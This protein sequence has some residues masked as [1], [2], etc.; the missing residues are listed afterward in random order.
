MNS[1]NSLFSEKFQGNLEQSRRVKLLEY[2]KEMYE[3]VPKLGRNLYEFEKKKGNLKGHLGKEK[4]QF[5]NERMPTLNENS[6]EAQLDHMID[7]CERLMSEKKLRESDE[8]L[9]NE[10]RASEYFDDSREMR[11]NDGVTEKDEERRMYTFGKEGSSSVSRDDVVMRRQDYF[12]NDPNVRRNENIYY[13]QSR[14]PRESYMGNQLNE[15]VPLSFRNQRPQDFDL[16]RSQSREWE[17]PQRLPQFEAS[18]RL[19]LPIAKWQDVKFD[20][21]EEGL[22]R[23]LNRVTQM[24]IAE[25]ASKEDLFRNKI[26]LFKGNAADWLSTQT[27]FRD[28][29]DLVR[30]LT[31]YVRGSTSD[32]DRLRSIERMRQTPN[33]TCAV[34]ITRMEL[35]LND[36]KIP[37]REGEAV[38]MIIRAMLPRFRTPLASNTWML[39]V[40]DLR[41]SARRVEKIVGGFYR[42][43]HEL[44]TYAVEAEVEE[45]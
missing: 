6:R 11:K 14:H 17:I 27:R 31:L 42:E 1:E 2:P 33:E 39:T 44:D 21:N 24:A 22:T 18:R 4:V 19:G 38:E 37:L 20:G 28:W 36:L 26:H 16:G 29:D 8:S 5:E 15:D 32:Q 9:R 10:K 43:V 34:F 3:T 12:R 13:D 7:L 41:E 45:K 30:E 25:G 35:A 23:F 40:R